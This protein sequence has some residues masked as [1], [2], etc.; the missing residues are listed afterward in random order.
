MRH[1]L[2]AALAALMPI[3]AR[4]EVPLT[5]FTLDNG[6]E[7]LVIEDH[8]APVVTH[9]VWYRVGAADE[10]PGKSGIAHFLE[11]LMF[12]GTDEIPEGAF[13]KIVAENGGQ[14]NAFTSRDQTAYYQRIAADRL[15]TVMRMEADRM[16][17]LVLSDAVVL[18][19][20]DVILEERNSRI[21]NNPG[22]LFGE[23]RDAAQFLNHPYGIPII[24]WKHEMESLT[25]EDAFAFYHRYYAPNNAILIVAGDVD[26]AEVEALAKTYYG[27]LEPTPGLG[28]RH[29]PLEP[30]QTAA[31]RLI[32][33]DAKVRQPY[34][35]RT[36]L[37]PVREPGDQRKAAALKL[38]AEL[39]GGS[40]LTSVLGQKLQLEQKIA[41]DAGAFYDATSYDPSTF[42]LYV[43]PAPGVTLQQ[44]EDAMDNVLADFISHGPDP[45]HLERVRAQVRADDIYALDSQF[46]LANRYGY[47]LTSGL[48]LA[49]VDE[50]PKLLQ[51]V[52]ADE[53]VAAAREV[54]DIRRS[55]TG[56]LMGAEEKAQ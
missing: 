45:E 30:P 31:R 35:V 42:G 18:P 1:I 54:F 53:I 16:R 14:D 29:R 25:R 40:G 3:L 44:A 2:I 46:G 12:K 24:G 15:E 56:W 10:P 43:V 6:M 28:P 9:M 32:Y 47:A 7:G 17:D 38:L 23:Q 50:W 41:L 39:L 8:R 11:H 52:G 26:P 22:A 4:A 51:E 13:S 21:E 37:A 55:V 48:T 5:R 19:E 49:D 34:V 27:P 33:N 20:R 36:Y